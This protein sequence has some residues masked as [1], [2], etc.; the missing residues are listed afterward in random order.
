[1]DGQ[2]GGLSGDSTKGWINLCRDRQIDGVKTQC[3]GHYQSYCAPKITRDFTLHNN[4]VNVS[5]SYC[6]YTSP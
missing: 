4:K 3:Y 5:L 2:M 1:M 6:T